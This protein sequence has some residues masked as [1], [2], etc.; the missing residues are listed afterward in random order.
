MRTRNITPEEKA[1]IL[2]AHDMGVSDE[3]IAERYGRKLSTIRMYIY[4]SRKDEY[5]LKREIRRKRN[6]EIFTLRA[7][8]LTFAEIGSMLGMKAKTVSKVY[9]EMVKDL[10]PELANLTFA[11]EK[12]PKAKPIVINGHRYWDVSDWYL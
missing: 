1:G 2:A 5:A 11:P 4:R 7:Q 6:A 12:K 9:Q 8:G 10:D 3:D